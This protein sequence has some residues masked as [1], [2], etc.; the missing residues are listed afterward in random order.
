[1]TKLKEMS[2]EEKREYIIVFSIFIISIIVGYFVGQNREWFRPSFTAAGYMAGS[3]MTCMALFSIYRIISF[4][5][6]FFNKKPVQ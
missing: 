4:V 6:S 2:K 5:A 1:M 3:L